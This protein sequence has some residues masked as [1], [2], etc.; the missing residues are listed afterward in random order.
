M[1]RSEDSILHSEKKC[2]EAAHVEG[3]EAQDRTREM[4][5]TSTVTMMCGTLLDQTFNHATCLPHH[6]T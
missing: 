4:Y 2:C 6:T 1:S 3:T 5:E